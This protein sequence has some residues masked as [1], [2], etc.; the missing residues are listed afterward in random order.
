VMAVVKT[1]KFESPRGPVAIDPATRDLI[2]NVYLR[3]LTMVR[4]QLENVEFETVPMVK[5]PT[6]TY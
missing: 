4:G 5:D 3:K 6:E 1:L 2:Q